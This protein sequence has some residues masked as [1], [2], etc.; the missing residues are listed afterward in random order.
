MSKEYVLN[1]EVDLNQEGGKR[2]ARASERHLLE[3]GFEVQTRNESEDWCSIAFKTD[4]PLSN[5]RGI[6]NYLFNTAE[7]MDVRLSSEIFEYTP[8]ILIGLSQLDKNPALFENLDINRGK[9]DA[10]ISFPSTRAR[11]DFLN[12]LQDANIPATS[13][14]TEKA[15]E[16]ETKNNFSTAT[17]SRRKPF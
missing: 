1:V 3:N 7:K 13:Y 10:E 4:K 16:V 8:Q 2:L 17:S 6:Q 14:F 15:L 5:V 11:D 9:V 12:F